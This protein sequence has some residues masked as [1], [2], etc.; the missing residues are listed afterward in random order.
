MIAFGPVPSRRLGRSLG[1]N[2]IPPKVCTYSCTYCQVGRTNRLRTSRGSFLSVAA[3]KAAVEK[4]LEAARRSGEPVDY[5]TFVPDGEPTLD[6]ALGSMIEA[7]RPLEV[8]IAVVTNGT[9][10]GRADVREELAGADWVSLKVDTVDERRWRQVNRPHRRLHLPSMLEGIR[11]FAAGFRGRLVTETML[12]ARLDDSEAELRHTASFI[13]SLQPETAYV[14]VP[15]RPPAE[16]WVE[17]A[18]PAN[19]TR[20]YE[21]F[22]TLVGRVE[23]LVGYEGNAF[24]TTGGPQEDLLAITAVHPMREEAVARLLGRAGAHATLVAELV[25][26]GELA[27]VD[28]GGHRYYLRPTRRPGRQVFREGR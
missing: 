21:V 1:I 20:A 26:R 7:L 23:L 17:P 8:P 11:V 16:P 27:A 13:G 24:T 2:H 19:V 14:A 15:T 25:R 4:K 10:L 3:V 6:A 9:L 28:Y 18:A 5:L 12:L 22:R